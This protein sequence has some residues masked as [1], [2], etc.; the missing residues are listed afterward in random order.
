MDSDI[1]LHVTH[2]SG[3]RMIMS[4]VD[5]LSRA[6]KSTG[7][8]QGTHVLNFVPLHL[9]ATDRSAAMASWL[10]RSFIHSPL[11]FKLLTPSDWFTTGHQPGHFI[12]CPPPAAAEVVVEQLAK[13]CHKRPQ[14]MHLVLVPKLMTGRWRRRLT[15]AC[16]GYFVIPIGTDLWQLNQCEG[17]LMFVCFPFL[18]H[19]PRFTERD[20][21]L[22]KLSR[23]LST[24]RVWS[25]LG[26][27][28][29]YFLCQLLQQARAL[30]PL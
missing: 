11:S 2:V 3:K 27:R 26:E 17:L 20:A 23:L 24:D 1:I 4:G 25:T 15:R 16:D 21:L 9:S 6:D 13:A 8:M 5:G 18:S 14:S 28:E 29:G 19:S 22:A 10:D 7:I 12:W 30:C